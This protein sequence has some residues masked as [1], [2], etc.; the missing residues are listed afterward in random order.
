MR[1]TKADIVEEL[2]RNRFAGTRAEAADFTDLIFEI[3][4]ETLARG[5]G[6]KLTG[7]GNFMITKKR[8]RIGRNLHTG[9]AIV[10]TE[11]RVVGFKASAMLK[12]DMN[13]V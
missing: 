4:K 13:K 12:K 3:M 8:E 6:L 2:W 10:I 11:R 1:L 9:E 5:E 7:F